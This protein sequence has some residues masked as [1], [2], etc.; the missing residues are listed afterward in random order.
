MRRSNLKT[1]TAKRITNVRTTSHLKEFF[2]FPIR[3]KKKPSARIS[4]ELLRNI[5]AFFG[6][7]RKTRRKK[8]ESREENKQEKA[9]MV[10][11]S[12]F[13]ELV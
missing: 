1:D 2:F 12:S 10:K 7:M 13:L 9:R 8:R 5:H 11:S 4:L 6:S 3:K